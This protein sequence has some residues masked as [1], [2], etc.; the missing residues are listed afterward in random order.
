MNN[1]LCSLL[2]SEWIWIII[3]ALIVINCCCGCN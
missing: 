3:V 1:C 2:N